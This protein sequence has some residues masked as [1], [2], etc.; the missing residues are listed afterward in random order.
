METQGPAARGGKHRSVRNVLIAAA[1]LAV[2]F[3][4]WAIVTAYRD[5]ILSGFGVALL[6][7]VAALPLAAFE[8]LDGCLPGPNHAG[9]VER[10][11]D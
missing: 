1:L 5:R 2:L 10:R 11:A 4:G 6:V 7:A 9:C 8:I 3:G